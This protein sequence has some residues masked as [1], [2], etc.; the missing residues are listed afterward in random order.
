MNVR[1]FLSRQ[2]RLSCW[3]SERSEQN[4]IQ[5]YCV[6]YYASPFLERS[7][8]NQVRSASECKGKPGTCIEVKI[9]ESVDCLH[10]AFQ[11]KKRLNK[12]LCTFTFDYGQF[13]R[14]VLHCFTFGTLI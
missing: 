8:N 11:K 3:V 13:E 1:V 5:H 4:Q 6:G 9:Y 2:D 12:H 14:E 7:Y 10:A